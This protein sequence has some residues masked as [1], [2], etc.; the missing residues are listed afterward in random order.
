MAKLIDIKG[1]WDMSYGFNFN[2]NFTSNP[3]C[4]NRNTNSI[5]VYF[6]IPK[7][8]LPGVIPLSEISIVLFK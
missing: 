8:P 2:F 1:Y 3:N 7:I 5:F 6:C 4:N